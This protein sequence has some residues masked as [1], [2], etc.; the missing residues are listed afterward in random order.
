[1]VIL[2]ELYSGPSK[3][4]F[5]GSRNRPLEVEE[6]K[7][8]IAQDRIL[9]DPVKRNRAILDILKERLVDGV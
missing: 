9:Q 1:M 6:E 8:T 5:V 3:R 4:E 2:V 7:G